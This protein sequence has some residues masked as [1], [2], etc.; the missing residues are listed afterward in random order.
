MTRF[1]RGGKLSPRFIGSFDIIEQIGEVAYRLALPPR[2][3][4]VYDVFHIS[5]LRQYEPYPSHVLELNGLELEAD[6]SFEKKPI[7]IL[8][9]S[10]QVLRGKMIHLVKVIRSHHGMEEAAWE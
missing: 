1:G 4:S 9:Q 3:S 5:I 6:V 2:I 7:E 10:D 8:D